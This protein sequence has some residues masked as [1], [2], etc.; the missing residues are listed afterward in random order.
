MSTNKRYKVKEVGSWK[1]Q[2]ALEL[3]QQFGLLSVFGPQ[4]I[5]L[6]WSEWSDLH[7]S[8]W[9]EPT[10]ETV[11]EVFEVELEEIPG[12]KVVGKIE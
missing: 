10:K 6:A 8:H 4:E 7:E 1:M 9:I 5:Y 3:G 12:A 2:Q 11:E